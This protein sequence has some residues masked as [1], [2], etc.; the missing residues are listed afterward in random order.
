MKQKLS[1][2]KL[3]ENELKDVKAGTFAACLTGTCCSCPS[4]GAMCCACVKPDEI[5]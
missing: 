1:L 5:Y 4:P 3:S 2:V